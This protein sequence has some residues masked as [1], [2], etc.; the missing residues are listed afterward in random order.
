M[1]NAQLQALRE[2]AAPPPGRPRFAIVQGSR[3]YAV[4][5]D[6]AQ[7]EDWRENFYPCADVV[8]WTPDTEPLVPFDGTDES[9]DL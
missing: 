6:R 8:E 7:A 1:T 9:P 5:L 4:D 3:V 2:L